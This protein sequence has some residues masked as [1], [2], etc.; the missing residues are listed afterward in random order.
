MGRSGRL[1]RRTFGE[2]KV[3]RDIFSKGREK[4]LSDFRKEGQTLEEEDASSA[5]RPSHKDIRSYKQ[6]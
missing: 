4:T 3:R 2:G 6:Q 5:T 1:G